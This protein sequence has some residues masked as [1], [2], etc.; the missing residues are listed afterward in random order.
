MNFMETMAN[1]AMKPDLMQFFVQVQKNKEQQEL[2]NS[3]TDRKL[4]I[5]N[6]PPGL[7]AQKVNMD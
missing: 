7:T 1:P 4:Y 3:K 2:K 5:G 6:I